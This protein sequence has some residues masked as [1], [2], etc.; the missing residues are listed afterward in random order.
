M[1]KKGTARPKDHSRV[2]TG[3]SIFS[4]I[5]NKHSTALSVLVYHILSALS[6]FFRFYA[7]FDDMQNPLEQAKSGDL[8]PQK[9]IRSP[10]FR[11]KKRT[12]VTKNA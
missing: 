10:H 1:P 4:T 9:S 12:N 5:I 6:I 3:E 11:A 2:R 8:I 7:P